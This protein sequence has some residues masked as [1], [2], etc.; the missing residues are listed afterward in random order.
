MHKTGY[1]HPEKRGRRLIL[2]ELFNVTLYNECTCKIQIQETLEGTGRTSWQSLGASCSYYSK[3]GIF[4]DEAIK[5][6]YSVIF[7]RPKKLYFMLDLFS[8]I[9]QTKSF[10]EDSFL[11]MT[12]TKIFR[13]DEFLD[14]PT[15]SYL[16]RIFFR[17]SKKVTYRLEYT[18]PDNLIDKSHSKIMR[19]F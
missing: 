14:S 6:S 12:C 1:C 5:S 17:E 4:S 19:T 8:R 11:R 10:R 16:M 9:T 15:S 7:A 3:K 2:S 13:E 18:S